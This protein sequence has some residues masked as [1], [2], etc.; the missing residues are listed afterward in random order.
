M[1][2]VLLPDSRYELELLAQR[3]AVAVRNR[4][5]DRRAR[6][7]VDNRDVSDILDADHARPAIDDVESEIAI[8]LSRRAERRMR[9]IDA[10]LARLSDGRYGRC[11][12]C[13]ARIPAARLL[14]VPETRYCLPC[15]LAGERVGGGQQ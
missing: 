3:D 1:T 6:D 9:D 5:L 12:R 10:A 13:D 2:A 15:K 4:H 11:E 7:A 14:A 8:A